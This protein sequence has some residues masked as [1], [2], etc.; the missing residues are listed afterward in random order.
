MSGKALGVI[1]IKKL[2]FSNDEKII[3]MSK[4]SFHKTSFREDVVLMTGAGHHAGHHSGPWVISFQPPSDNGSF[5]LSA[6]A[7]SAPWPSTS[8]Q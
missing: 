5:H 7:A 1:L 2:Y 8:T 3:F 4:R 6:Y